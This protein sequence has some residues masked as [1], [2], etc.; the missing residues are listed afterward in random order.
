M[1][2][3]PGVVD[4]NILATGTDSERDERL[5]TFWSQTDQ[6]QPG[7]SLKD[8]GLPPA[9]TAYERTKRYYS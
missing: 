6:N 7:S 8:S 2:L 3:A 5:T 9:K 4:T 1:K